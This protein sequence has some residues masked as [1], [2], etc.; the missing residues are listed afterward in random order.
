MTVIMPL[1]VL[2]EDYIQNLTKIK[3]FVQKFVRIQYFVFS[4]RYF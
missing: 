3:K 4:E 1:S 2:P